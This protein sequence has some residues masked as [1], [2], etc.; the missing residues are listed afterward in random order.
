MRIPEEHSANNPSDQSSQVE[1][2]QARPKNTNNEPRN[3]AST[4]AGIQQGQNTADPLENSLNPWQ[5]PGVHPK[6]RLWV[7][8]LLQLWQPKLRSW[9]QQGLLIK[10]AAQALDLDHN[11][12]PAL[13]TALVEQLKEGDISGLPAI[14][15]LEQQSMPQKLH[16]I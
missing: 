3:G 2:V 6:K 8:S 5:L 10:A 7:E 13:L 1:S 14:R 16:L 15:L 9:A 11:Q 4:E 12:P